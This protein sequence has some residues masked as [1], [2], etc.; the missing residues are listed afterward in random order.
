MVDDQ[1]GQNRRDRGRERQK[2]HGNGTHD[3]V[4]QEGGT[5]WQTPVCQSAAN[6]AV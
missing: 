6:I 2:E 3:I 4:A 5:S 1:E